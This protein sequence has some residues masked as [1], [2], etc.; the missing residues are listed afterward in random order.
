MFFVAFML[1]LLISDLS[2]SSSFL[3]ISILAS[4]LFNSFCRSHDELKNFTAD[5]ITAQ[6][7]KFNTISPKIQ[8]FLTNLRRITI[9]LAFT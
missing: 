5:V 9:L 6:V 4:A 1:K 2:L 8:M 7:T 3:M